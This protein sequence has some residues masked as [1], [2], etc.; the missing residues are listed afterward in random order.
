VIP[1][2]AI[3]CFKVFGVAVLGCFYL[4]LEGV[5]TMPGKKAGLLEGQPLRRRA[6]AWGLVQ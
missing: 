6:F 5:A 3:A 2:S 1:A 4:V